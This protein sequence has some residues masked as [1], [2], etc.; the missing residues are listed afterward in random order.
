MSVSGDEAGLSAPK[1]VKGR[2]QRLALK[3]LRK[4]GAD[5]EIPTNIRFLFYELEQAGHV[6]KDTVKLDGTPGKRKPSADLTNAVTALRELRLIPWDWIVD[7]SRHIS[8]WRVDES[9]HSYILDTVRRAA[10]DRFQGVPRPVLLTESR[11]IGGILARSVA[12]DYRVT[13]APTGGQSNGFLRTQVAD[14]LRKGDV[15]PL[16]VGDAD[17]AG[18]DI[19]ANTRRVLTRLR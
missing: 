11:A 12:R 4:K 8:A 7:E 16:Y 14:Y 19:E 1:T 9:V 17:N 5:G 6:S 18:N 15:R 13:V 3:W 2:L 10:I